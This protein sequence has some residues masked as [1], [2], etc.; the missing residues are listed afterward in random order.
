[1]KK[2]TLIWMA[3]AGILLLMGLV[4]QTE[5]GPADDTRV[6]IDHEKFVYSAPSCFDEAGLTNNLEETTL[7]EALALDYEPESGC[8]ANVFVK[9]KKPI[10]IGWFQ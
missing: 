8:T 3:L 5:V 6:I 1:M 2:G 10:L 9:E 4:V 7:G